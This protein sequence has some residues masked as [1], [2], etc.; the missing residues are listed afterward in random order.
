MDKW[1]R[2]I[3]MFLAAVLLTGAIGGVLGSQFL[4]P[5]LVGLPI[6]SKINWI[7]NGCEGVTVINR[8]EKVIVTENQGIE[9]AISRASG[10]VAGVISENT[11][12][13]IK[14]K[15]TTLPEPEILAQGTG[16]FISSDGLLA[17]PDLFVPEGAQKIIILTGDKQLEA[18]IIQRDQKNGLVLLKIEES[19]LPVLPFFEGDLKLG[20]R[21]F[22]IDAK[23]SNLSVNLGF[24]GA[25]QPQL[26]VYFQTQKTTGGPIFNVNGEIVGLGFLQS[27]DGQM[28]VL[29]AKIIHEFIK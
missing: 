1:K 8:T 23:T 2:K 18:K 12:K 9:E 16:I 25:L 28:A 29:P 10:T 24:V 3:W 19:N 26:L 21:I 14:G 5:W 27:P 4:L 15:R 7:K 13:I 6:F 22:L 20:E 11:E 17:T